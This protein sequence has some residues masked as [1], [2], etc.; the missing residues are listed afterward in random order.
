MKIMKHRVKLMYKLLFVFF[1][2]ISSPLYSNEFTYHCE[3]KDNLSM[4]FDVNR[5]K[6]SIIH[7]HSIDKTSNYVSEVNRPLEI[8]EWD[9]RKDSV[10]TLLGD[11]ISLTLTTILF[12]FQHQKL[13]LQV[14]F[15][16]LMSEGNN[17]DDLA[18]RRLFNCYSI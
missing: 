13:V 6:K 18:V 11:P 4:V 15:N 5:T 2:V 12:N 8:Y 1:M 7:T 9:E 14:T 3:G 16:V 10:W 17:I